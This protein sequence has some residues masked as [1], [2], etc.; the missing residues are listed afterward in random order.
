MIL[1]HTLIYRGHTNEVNQIKF[2]NSRTRIASAS[3]D[4]TARIWTIGNLGKSKSSDEIPG[5]GVT[6]PETVECLVL[7]GHAD[8]IGNLAWCPIT[9]TGS[10]ELLATASFDGSARL[11]D[12]T[13]GVCLRAISDHKRAIYTLKFSHD[14][15]H[16][17]SG[18]GDGWLYVYESN[19]CISFPLALPYN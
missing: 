6:A 17:V 5:L 15:I 12:A 3:D 4:Q 11:W 14:G 10:N 16:F 2:N 19:V 1:N 9:P 7:E 13:T 8:S 18:S